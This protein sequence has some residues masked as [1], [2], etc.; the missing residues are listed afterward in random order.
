[1]QVG[2]LRLLRHGP[3]SAILASGIAL[4]AAACGSNSAGD[5]SRVAPTAQIASPVAATATPSVTPVAVAASP[6]PLPA[7]AGA[8]KTGAN[9]LLYTGA[10]PILLVTLLAP[11]GEQVTA[12]GLRNTDA[13]PIEFIPGRTQVGPLVLPAA[14]LSVEM[15]TEAPAPPGL[16]VKPS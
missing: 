13:L 3:A 6:L 2:K 5:R 16:Q 10:E 1:M 12:V 11:L 8:L 14:T 9:E 15:R 4:V 7:G